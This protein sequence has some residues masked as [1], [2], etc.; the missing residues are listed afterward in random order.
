MLFIF[1]HIFVPVCRINAVQS[2]RMQTA[3]IAQKIPK[4]L[5]NKTNTEEAVQ[6]RQKKP[7]EEL[8]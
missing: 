2:S 1:S 7:L 5:F 8:R 4:T 3:T 6:N